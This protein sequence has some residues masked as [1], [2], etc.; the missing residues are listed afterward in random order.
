METIRHLGF[1]GASYGALI[2]IIGGLI[3]WLVTDHRLQARALAELEQRGA[4]R[5]SERG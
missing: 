3:V 2:I 5:R 4:K 1:I